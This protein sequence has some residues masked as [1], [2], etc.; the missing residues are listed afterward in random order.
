M[1]NLKLS[2]LHENLITLIYW[3]N[4]VIEK[5]TAGSYECGLCQVIDFPYARFLTHV[6]FSGINNVVWGSHF[7]VYYNVTNS[8]GP[9]YNNIDLLKKPEDKEIRKKFV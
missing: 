7:D 9:K 6:S 1:W 8:K 3:P 5:F 4:I 2:I